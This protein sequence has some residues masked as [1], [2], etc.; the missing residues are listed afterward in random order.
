MNSKANPADEATRGLSVKK[1]AHSSQWLTGPQFLWQVEKHWPK[2][3]LPSKENPF[4][5]SKFFNKQVVASDEET[6]RLIQRFSSL[7]RLKKATAWLLRYKLFRL[8]EFE[9]TA[10]HAITKGRIECHR[11][12]V[13]RTRIN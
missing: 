1:L 11:I 2:S 12:A 9:T 5:C 7:Y 8:R 6:D 10:R 3:P 4:V 13:C